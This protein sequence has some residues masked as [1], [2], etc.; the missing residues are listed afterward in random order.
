[1]FSQSYFAVRQ[2]VWFL[3]QAF[4]AVTSHD[5]LLQ[6]HLNVCAARALCLVSSN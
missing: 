4:L 5:P 1:M 6:L 2:C 3:D